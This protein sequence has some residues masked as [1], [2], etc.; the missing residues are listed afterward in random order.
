MDKLLIDVNTKKKKEG[1]HARNEQPT[2]R[3]V[4]DNGKILHVYFKVC[5]Y[6]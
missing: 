2:K 6:G 4:W 5:I 3:K 1:R